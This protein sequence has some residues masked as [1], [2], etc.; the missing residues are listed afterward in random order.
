M[1]FYEAV[2]PTISKT[3]T[4]FIQPEQNPPEFLALRKELPTANPT[5]IFILGSA[6][7]NVPS[8]KTLL[9]RLIHQA[10]FH[11]FIIHKRLSEM[12]QRYSCGDVR[13]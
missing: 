6:K 13:T 12:M 1:K 11:I 4:L 2:I 5:E 3:A 10:I 7:N 9:K 8:P